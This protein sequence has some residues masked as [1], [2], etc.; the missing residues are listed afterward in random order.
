MHLSSEIMYCQRCMY[1]WSTLAYDPAIYNEDYCEDYQRR[2]ETDIGR[3]INLHRVGL[4]ARYVPMKKRLL[5]FG[6]GAGSFLN[7]AKAYWECE[8]VEANRR[9]IDVVRR[10]TDLP[11]WYSLDHN[12]RYDCIT[13]WDSLEHIENVKDN[14]NSLLENL[15]PGGIVVVTMPELQFCFD[16]T[17]DEPYLQNV[18]KN[19]RHA[20]PREHLSYWTKVGMERFLKQSGLTVIRV[21]NDESLLRYDS[22]NPRT[23][24]M[25][26][27]ARKPDLIDEPN[28]GPFEFTVQH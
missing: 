14:F 18:F 26:L 10:A 11:V 17:R 25:S 6:C 2:S 21:D 8:G 12:Q 3:R 16:S 27:V 1:G 9:T 22:V 13:F 24:I 28:K 19:W 4:V 5:D 7:S 23:N 20:K 15:A